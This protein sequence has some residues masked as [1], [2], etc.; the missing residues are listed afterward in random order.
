MA[1]LA[2]GVGNARSASSGHIVV[3]PFCATEQLAI[4]C[5]LFI[6]D[7]ASRILANVAGPLAPEVSVSCADT[8]EDIL[9]GNGCGI[10][11]PGAKCRHLPN[12]KAHLPGLCIDIYNEHSY[13][14]TTG[15]LHVELAGSYQAQFH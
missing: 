3:Y 6:N 2:P 13:I 5:V 14:T 10:F 15:V 4:E 8:L 11:E 1:R 7:N 12:A 9:A